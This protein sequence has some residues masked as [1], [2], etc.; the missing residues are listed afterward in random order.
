MVDAEGGALP[1]G[2]E[3]CPGEMGTTAFAHLPAGPKPDIRT[4]SSQAI[5][6]WAQWIAST[7]Q[8]V[9]REARLVANRCSQSHQP[10]RAAQTRITS[11]R[12]CMTHRSHR[13][14]VRV[15]AFIALLTVVAIHVLVRNNEI[16]VPESHST[17]S[18]L[19]DWSALSTWRKEWLP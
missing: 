17:G 19:I 13:A 3:R 15:P 7:I 16:V 6:A 12:V 11:A 4:F 14:R 8:P 18:L 1:A 9:R 5:A 2:Q 10:S